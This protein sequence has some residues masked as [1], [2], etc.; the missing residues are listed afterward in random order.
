[1]EMFT[2]IMTRKATQATIKELR[3]IGVTVE[4]VPCGY[5]ASYKGDV[6]FRAMNGRHNYMVSL[7][8]GIFKE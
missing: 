2:R 6:I 8:K 1:M 7:A 5:E 3:S 4:A